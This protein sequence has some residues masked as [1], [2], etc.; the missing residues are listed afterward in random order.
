MKKYFTSV[1]I[2][3]TI[4]ISF[5]SFAQLKVSSSGNVGI[6]TLT[7]AYKLDVNAKT[8]RSYYQS[9][10]P[11]ILDVY[12]ADPRITTGSHIVFYRMDGTD[13]ANIECKVCTEYSDSTAKENISLLKNEGLSTILQLRGVSFS[14]KNDK[15]ETKHSGF[16]AQEVESILPGAVY[17]DDSLKHKSLSYS[18]IIPYLVEAIKEQQ[19][20]I[21]DQNA[22]LDDF[23]NNCCNNASLKSASIGNV[24]ESDVNVAKL[25]QNAPNPF[26]TQ[27]I[28]KFE[29]PKTVG[30][31]QL[32]ICNMNG[33]L[34]KTIPINQRGVGNVTIR[35]NEFKAG[36]YL[37]SLVDDGKIIDTKQMLLTE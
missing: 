25:Y 5:N 6:N 22:R 11:F 33:T 18:A 12:H 35:G 17:T 20:T 16:L 31:A 27:T 7:P 34:L 24:N 9:N 21:E 3:G 15:N 19:H 28:I 2:L 29:I 23:E 8:L 30:N 26:T 4:L 10:Q 13:F 1:F 36:M 37:Y 32:Y 14:W